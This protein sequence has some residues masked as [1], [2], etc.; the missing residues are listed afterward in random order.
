MRIGA[1]PQPGAPGVGTPFEAR[2][3]AGDQHDEVEE[4]GLPMGFDQSRNI[5][6]DAQVLVGHPARID[7]VDE[8]QH[9]LPWCIDERVVE[10]VVD[11]AMRQF[12]CLVTNDQGVSVVEYNMRR[13]SPR[14]APSGQQVG[15]TPIRDDRDV[16][17][18][19]QVRRLTMAVDCGKVLDPGIATSNILGGSVWGLSGMQTAVAFERGSAQQNNFDAFEPLHL[20]QTPPT[21]VR[22]V[23]RGKAGRHWRARPGADPRRGV[24]RHLAATRRRHSVAAVVRCRPVICVRYAVVTLRINGRSETVDA[25]P[26][27]PLLWVVREQLGLTGTKFGCGIAACGACTVHVDGTAVVLVPAE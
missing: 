14:I 21:E 27:T 2:D 25:G 3:M 17:S 7:D 22:F 24:Q 6:S 5:G 11:P 18:S 13:W 1:R 19:T 26:D 23:Q 4:Q 10:A 20:W 15:R 9:A 8:H 16:A 12:Q